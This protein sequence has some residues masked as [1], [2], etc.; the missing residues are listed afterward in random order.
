MMLP[1]HIKDTGSSFIL[2]EQTCHRF[3]LDEIHLAT[4]NFDDAL[5]IGRGGFGKVYRCLW[6]IESVN[7]VVVKRLHSM[8]NQGA[9]EFEA[10]VKILSKLRHGNL[11]SLIGYCNEGKDMCLVYEFMPNGTLEDHLHKGDTELSW[12]QRQKI[13]VGAARVLD[14]LHTGTSTQHGVIHRDVKSS[15]ILLDANFAAKISD[16]GLAKVGPVNQTRTYVSTGVKGTLDIWVLCGKQTVDSSLDEEQWSLAAW[17]KDKIKKGK[18]NKI[19]NHRLMEQTSKKC[20]KEFASIACRCLHDQPKQRPTMAEVVVRLDSV[21]LHER[22]SADS[23]VDEG[24][25]INKVRYL[26]TGKADSIPARAV[27]TKTNIRPFIYG[28]FTSATY[29]FDYEEFP[30]RLLETIYKGWADD[31]THALTDCAFDLAMCVRK[32]Y[33]GKSEVL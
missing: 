15:N 4:R 9:H 16:F 17:A 2:P 24:R 13:C 11:V 12:L 7:Q 8:S 32:R 30:K 14:Y 18:L 5:V 23:G 29:N 6:K 20:L 3:T 27:I 33:I 21:L 19:I 25:F 31:E 28:E 26:F 22:E 10:E 1:G